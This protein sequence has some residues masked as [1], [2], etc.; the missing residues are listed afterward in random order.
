MSN[1]C[2]GIWS[3]LEMDD[4]D[5]VTFAVL[6]TVMQMHDNMDEFYVA[7]IENH[8][9]ISS[10]Y[11]NFLAINSSAGD[12]VDDN[13]RR[14]SVEAPVRR[15]DDP[16]QKLI[17]IRPKAIRRP[18]ISKSPWSLLRISRLGPSGLSL[19]FQDPG[20]PSGSPTQ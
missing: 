19:G 8:A 6:W 9:S 14:V 10:E 3:S 2:D 12:V 15:A 4:Q 7:Q 16:R 13:V 5:E 18:R 1:L 17:G 11:V 20:H